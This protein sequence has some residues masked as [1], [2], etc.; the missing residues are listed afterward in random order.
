MGRIRTIKPE[1]WRNEALSELPEATHMLAAA[2]LNYVDDEGYFN[3]NTRLVQAECCPLRE[4]SVS[5]H[6]ALIQLQKAG[7]LRL[8][9]CSDGRKYGHI[10]HFLDHQVINRATI[11][12]ISGLEI[13]W[14][15]SMSTHGALSEPSLREGNGTERNG[16]ERNARAESEFEEWYKL[17]PRHVGRGRAL[18]A[19]TAARKKTDHATLMAG[20]KLAIG[21][22]RDTETQFIPHPATW[23]SGEYWLDDQE[24][25]SRTKEQIAEDA[26][27]ASIGDNT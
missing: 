10:I 1:F 9:A 6:G 24:A 2:L 20:A 4:P 16:R 7:Y 15:G 13:V 5:I 25:P 3:A 14:D 22:Y 23:L 26:I 8:G 21:R 18:K 27:Y 19:Y 11:S 12:K 17:Y